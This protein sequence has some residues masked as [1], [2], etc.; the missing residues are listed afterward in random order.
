M[1]LNI[2]PMIVTSVHLMPN[3]EETDEEHANSFTLNG[4]V[5]LN[6]GSASSAKLT[7]DATLISYGNYEVNLTAEF[8]I[9]FE[10]EVTEDEAEEIIEQAHT[11][12]IIFPYIS[13]YISALVSLSGYQRP[14]IPIVP[15]W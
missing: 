8:I 10:R 6:Q 3:T 12:A 13:S 15:F 7:S 14:S 11:E 5:S 2:A 1:K 9:K 4:V